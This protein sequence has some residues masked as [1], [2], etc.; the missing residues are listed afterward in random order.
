MRE[1]E[2]IRS[3]TLITNQLIIRW[4]NSDRKGNRAGKG[5]MFWSMLILFSIFYGGLRAQG[6]P[7]RLP[8]EL[9]TASFTTNCNGERVQDLGTS[10]HES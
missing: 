6:E 8:I 5:K 4:L 9:S 2:F 10:V 1:R 7:F 3:R